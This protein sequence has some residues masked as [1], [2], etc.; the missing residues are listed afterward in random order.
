MLKKDSALS[1][2]TN[3]CHF[4]SIF[5]PFESGNLEIIEPVSIYLKNTAPFQPTLFFRA[6][7]K[8][9]LVQNIIN[10][11]ASRLITLSGMPGVGKSS[12]VLST[13]QWMEQRF[14]LRGGSIYYNARDIL[15]SVTFTR[16]LC[17]QLI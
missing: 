12:L 15:C 3:Q 10:N 16:K 8:F 6:V 14:L 17:N 9:K 7:D 13:L 11:K 4:C 5:G 2:T 1:K